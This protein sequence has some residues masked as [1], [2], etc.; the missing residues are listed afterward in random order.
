[1]P[2]DHITWYLL[3]PANEEGA[4]RQ[5]QETHSYLQ[6]MCLSFPST[7]IP[8]AVIAFYPKIPQQNR[9]KK[10]ETDT[11]ITPYVS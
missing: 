7:E 1:M 6:A 11:E 8:L 2:V 4:T 5:E 3:F 9:E 10:E